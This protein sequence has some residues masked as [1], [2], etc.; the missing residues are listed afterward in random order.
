[1]KLLLILCYASTKASNSGRRLQLQDAK[2]I[3]KSTGKRN[4]ELPDLPV[5]CDWR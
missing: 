5:C 2:V 4:Y 3:S 1:M